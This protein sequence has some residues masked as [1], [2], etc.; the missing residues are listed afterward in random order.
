MFLRRGRESTRPGDFRSAPIRG[1]RAGPLKVRRSSVDPVAGEG[2][3][4]FSMVRT[5]IAVTAA[6]V[7]SAFACGHDG[8]SSRGPTTN[9]LRAVGDGVVLDSRTSL[10]WTS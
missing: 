2:H 6:L 3:P 8:S 7:L 4:R 10:E 5:P 9:R 1:A